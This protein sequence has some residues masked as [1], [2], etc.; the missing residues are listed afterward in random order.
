LQNVLVIVAGFALVIV[1]FAFSSQ[2]Y[3]A[4]L[5]RDNVKD[6]HWGPVLFRALLIFHGALLI[7]F[8]V[9][10]GR[11]ATVEPKRL[12]E[13]SPAD[14]ER[15]TPVTVVALIALS[16]VALALRLW[17]L[18]SDLWIDEVFTLLDFVR[19]PVGQIMTSFPSQNQHMLFSV[20]AHISTNVFGES[21]WSLRLP[22]VLL[23]VASICAFFFFCKQLLGNREAWLA[24]ALMT[25][26]YH[27]IWFSQN[28]RGYMGLLLFTITA[29]WCWLN[30]LNTNKWKW[31]IGYLASVVLGMWIHPTMAFVMAAHGLVHVV[32][33]MVPALGGT[34]RSLER[35]A[36]IR[37]FLIWF[38]SIS[39]TLQLYALSLPEFL[40]VG[41]H[42]ESPPNSEWTNPL[43]LVT[44]S[45][46]SLSI[47][48]GGA[49]ILALGAALVAFGWIALFRRDRRAAAVMTLPPIFAGTTMVILGHNI[50][51]RFF[52]F[53]MAFGLL[54]VVHGAVELPKAIFRNVY[55]LRENDR[56]ISNVGVVFACLLLVASLVMVP[57]NYAL[58]KQDFSGPK[59]Y[60][61]KN[62]S[63]NDAVIAVSLAGIVYGN[64]LTH[65]PVA[66]S[67]TELEILQ[68]NKQEVWLVYTLPIEV[69]SAKPELWNLIEK[70]YQVVKVFP[71]TLSGGDVYVC[72]RKHL[73][74]VN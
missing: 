10:R 18:N 46:K 14:G 28:A 64:Y 73:E 61:E 58:P 16:L 42:E 71:G 12:Y 4:F 31:W 3:T 2:D 30:G 23:G 37:P 44:E 70:D 29:T 6:L 7:Y 56:L 45:I 40:A 17:N 47:G 60:I 26:S 67:V 62:K 57:R 59:E 72:R 51:P 21:A 22:S 11:S 48:F 32:L 74:L 49:V 50:W 9:A 20:L 27:H 66:K 13:K 68:Q 24:A 65:W 38:L 43:W 35:F 54:I 34:H 5:L 15:I 63:S 39:V 36:G 1:G 41:L 19:Q 8:G 33:L 55:R 52:F 69:K 25:V 53:S